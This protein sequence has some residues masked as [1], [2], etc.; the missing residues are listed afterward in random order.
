LR[1]QQ[2]ETETAARHTIDVPPHASLTVEQAG[3]LNP[4]PS[5]PSAPARIGLFGNEDAVMKNVVIINDDCVES[6]GASGI[7][8]SSIRLL[9]QRK[10]NVTL[11]TGDHGNNPELRDLG[12]NVVAYGGTHILNGPTADAALRGLYDGGARAFIEKW[13]ARNDSADTVYHLHNW[14]KV[15]SPSI[16]AALRPV[17]SR[18][19]MSLHDYF[20]VCPNGAYFIFPQHV[21]CD[22]TPMSMACL[23]AVCDRRRHSH[24]LW[25]VARHS[26]RQFYFDLA[27]TPAT[28]LAVHED[29]VPYLERGGCNPASIRVLRNPVTPWRAERVEAE[30]NHEVFF[31]GRLEEDKGIALLAK[32]A[33]FAGAQLRVFGEGALKATIARECPSAIL[34]GWKSHAE[35]RV[36]AKSARLLVLPTCWRET[37][38]LVA[39][40]A[41]MSGIP[42]IVSSFPLIAN[43]V[44]ERKYGLACNP[45]DI[46]ELARMIRDLL[47]D[48]VSVRAMSL[49]GFNSARQSAPTPDIWCDALLSLYQAKLDAARERAIET[50]GKM[51]LAG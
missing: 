26:V 41:S 18:L 34:M 37:F 2:F 33:H 36:H 1:C 10:I 44:V 5:Y 14:H 30:R 39:F 50:P 38:G 46:E 16:F 40:E 20:L 51:M 19:V 35:I 23:Q 27:T 42:L 8:L 29:M 25:R 15:L 13:I 31:V 12:V 4:F 48:D 32:A 28:L 21:C 24:K 9:R 7:A 17:A 43:E 47:V 11:L 22:R 3:T 49:C 6:G 45:Y